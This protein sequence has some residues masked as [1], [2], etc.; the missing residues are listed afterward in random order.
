M[1]SA[2][3]SIFHKTR[4]ELLNRLASTVERLGKVKIQLGTL[5][6]SDLAMQRR[7]ESEAKGLRDE[8]ANIKAALESWRAANESAY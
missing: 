3:P 1:A 8:Y 7:L 2:A 5:P 6:S 4:Q